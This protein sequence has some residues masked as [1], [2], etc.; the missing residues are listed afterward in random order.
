MGQ[1]LSVDAGAFGRETREKENIG[2]QRPIAIEELPKSKAVRIKRRA[3]VRK[4][5][6]E[7]AGVTSVRCI[8]FV[9]RSRTHRTHGARRGYP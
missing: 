1:R 9:A 8:L 2:N 6:S 4:P 7:N 3:R 5:A